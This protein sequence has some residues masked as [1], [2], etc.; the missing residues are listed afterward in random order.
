[1][2]QKDVNKKKLGRGG[3]A[4]FGK[5]P[6]GN[7]RKE[8]SPWIKAFG[9]GEKKRWVILVLTVRQR[10]CQK[11]ILSTCGRGDTCVG[12]GINGQAEDGRKS[13]KLKKG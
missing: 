12:G 8:R 4:V 7:A 2:M 5:H 13:I 1:M 10:V 9:P 6:G 11:E 3:E